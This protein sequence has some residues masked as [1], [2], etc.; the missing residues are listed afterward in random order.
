[1]IDADLSDFL[2]CWTEIDAFLRRRTAFGWL[3]RDAAKAVGVA[4][5]RR[6]DT[7]FPTAVKEILRRAAMPLERAAPTCS[8]M[9]L[10]GRSF[11]VRLT[12][13]A[14]SFVL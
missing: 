14:S 3:Q 2:R 5:R 8:T 4:D 12:S 6:R 1:M 13:F 10:P 7:A 11:F 9:R